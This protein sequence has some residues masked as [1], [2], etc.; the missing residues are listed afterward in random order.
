MMGERR[1]CERF[2]DSRCCDTEYYA[3]SG[4]DLNY[5][6]MTVCDGMC[7]VRRCEALRCCPRK[8]G[9]AYYCVSK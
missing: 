4:D 8:N 3:K 2:C 7:C 5:C 1:C 9:D 6:V